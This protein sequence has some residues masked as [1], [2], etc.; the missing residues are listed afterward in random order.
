VVE[1]PP[2]FGPVALCPADLFLENPRAAGFAQRRALLGEV[3]T[4]GGDAGIPLG[5][6]S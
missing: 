6:K 3:L 1:Q 4:L 2:Q 5:Q